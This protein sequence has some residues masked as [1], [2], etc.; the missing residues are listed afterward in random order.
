MKIHTIIRALACCTA[1]SLLF[2]VGCDSPDE[3]TTQTAMVSPGALELCGGCGEFKGSS[4]CCTEEAEKCAGCS[5]TKGSPGCCRM[6]ADGKTYVCGS[7]GEIKGSEG[8]CDEYATRCDGC[9]MI[10]GSPGCCKMPE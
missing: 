5:M 4:G 1:L 2:I 6:N 8:C 9:G 10:K 3:T 7:C